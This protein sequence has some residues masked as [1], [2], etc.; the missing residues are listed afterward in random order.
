MTRTTSMVAASL[1]A[2]ALVTGCG[3]T[4]EN[5]VENNAENTAAQPSGTTA[6]APYQ[7]A[8]V[9]L[10]GCVQRGA[11]SEYVLT[12]VATM[13]MLPSSPG[14]EEGEGSDAG[15][16]EG[17]TDP[18][19]RTWT[20]PDAST[21]ESA[22]QVMANS[23]YLLIPGDEDLSEHVDKRV[24]IRGRLSNQPGGA[25]GT[26]GSAAGTQGQDT[27]TGKASGPTGTTVAGSPTALRALYVGSVR[28]VAD[29]CQR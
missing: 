26:S 12:S 14:G 28:P 23:T 2:A 4:P 27:A 17:G 25:V 19:G 20:A 21:P 6:D 18:R 11:G 24:A 7:T 10:T 5:N 9:T 3:R 16:T 13:G 8:A 22:G 15:R 1:F 29:S